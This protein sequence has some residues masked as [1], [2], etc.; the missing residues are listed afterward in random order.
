M[1][2]HIFPG[3]PKA[4]INKHHPLFVPVST[5]I[6]PSQCNS[7]STLRLFSHAKHIDFVAHFYRSFPL[8]NLRCYSN[9][10]SS[11]GLYPE[12]R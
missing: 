6:T 10:A 12:L 11:Q 1:I 4:A 2:D 5:E 8:R 9:M 7:V 3:F